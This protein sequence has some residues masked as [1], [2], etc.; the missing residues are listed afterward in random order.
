M[1]QIQNP[2]KV[3]EALKSFPI[4][5][6]FSKDYSSE[7]LLL[8]YEKDEFLIREGELN[9][10]LFFTH[11]G[12]V[13]CFSYS[14]NGKTQFITYM[15]ASEAIGLIGTIW[16]KPAVSN[17]QAVHK[18]QCL[19]LPMSRY[20][21]D[22]LNDN[23]FLRYLCHQLGETLLTS[24]RYLQVI[25]CSS[26]E[27]KIAAVILGNAENG[28]CHLN[29]SST[30][31]VVGTTYRHVLRVLNKFCSNHV[32]EKSGRDYIIKDEAYLSLCSEDAYDYIVNEHFNVN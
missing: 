6:I 29:L 14:S 30:A 7:F 4:S 9:N 24:N 11:N 12:T 27:S 22:L 13:K 23:K 32:L 15:K 19:A 1:K 20:R 5:D 18:C 28:I 2:L 31:E 26:I 8:E 10:Y 16:G 3:K 21:N 17:I 25:Q